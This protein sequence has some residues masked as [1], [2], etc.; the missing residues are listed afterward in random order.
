MGSAVLRGIR[1]SKMIA[2]QFNNTICER[3][4]DLLFIEA[5]TTDFDFCRLLLDKTDLKGKTFKVVGAE[6]SKEDKDLGE[7]DI[8]VIIDW[9][10]YSLDYHI[11]HE[12]D[13]LSLPPDSPFIYDPEF[14]RRADFIRLK[15]LS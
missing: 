13:I 3:D 4:M 2:L 6:L 5:V 12:M 15:K 11:Y 14:R 8:T 9:G 7:S 10:R 1:V